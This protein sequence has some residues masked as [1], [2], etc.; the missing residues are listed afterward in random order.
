[1][2]ADWLELVPD[3][4]RHVEARS[5]LLGGRAEIFGESVSGLVLVD[6][7]ARL[8]SVIGDVPL[9]AVEEA[10]RQLEGS[11]A[12]IGDPALNINLPGRTKEL[13][14]L[15]QLQGPARIDSCGLGSSPL[16]KSSG[17]LSPS[18]C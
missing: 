17:M 18:I 5:A 13:A 3:I 1:M 7:A 11:G 8:A 2:R 14:T 4:P 6:R 15:Y 16:T 12:V 9:G 10:A